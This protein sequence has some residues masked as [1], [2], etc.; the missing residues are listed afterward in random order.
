MHNNDYTKDNLEE[1]FVRNREGMLKNMACHE[2]AILVKYF[3]LTLR[4]CE[5]RAELLKCEYLT[6]G[7][8]SDFSQL[9]F[10]VQTDVTRV[11]AK[12]D[13]CGGNNFGFSVVE[14]KNGEERRGVVPADEQA[15]QD[16]LKSNP[17]IQVGY[18]VMQ[19]QMYVDAISS[20]ISA[21]EKKTPCALMTLGEA[22]T[23]LEV[24]SFLSDK[25]KTEAGGQ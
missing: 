13:R 4:D 1:C 22:K 20:F 5:E 25:F 12:I 2:L 18:L 17:E 24:A 14:S 16:E 10:A 8:V 21:V 3:G 7:G 19:K 9:E 11:T 6:L 23:V 15:F